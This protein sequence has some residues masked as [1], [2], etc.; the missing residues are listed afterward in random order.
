MTQKVR[1]FLSLNDSETLVV[2]NSQAINV[3]V[4]F[5]GASFTIHI[6]NNSAAEGTVQGT[7]AEEEDLSSATWTDIPNSDIAADT[8]RWITFYGT[9][10][11][12]RVNLTAGTCS[13]TMLN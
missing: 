2:G 6:T 4:P 8:D 10:T 3:G 13:A 7:I 1:K 11:H 5:S 12:F 9:A